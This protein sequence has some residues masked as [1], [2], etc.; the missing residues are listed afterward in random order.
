MLIGLSAADAALAE[1][2]RRR[3]RL[4]GAVPGR[5]DLVYSQDRCYGNRIG[6]TDADWSSVV[7]GG[8]RLPSYRTD[9]SGF[10]THAC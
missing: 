6:Y 4:G 10:V 3:V 2:A 8:S 7:L 1:N 9:C 5:N